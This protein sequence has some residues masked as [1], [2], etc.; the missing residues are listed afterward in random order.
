MS[1]PAN[2][3]RDTIFDLKEQLKEAKRD[4]EIAK[5]ERNRVHV[6]LRREYN[7]RLE[8]LAEERDHW[9]E[10]ATLAW[11]DEDD[12]CERLNIAFMEAGITDVDFYDKSIREL[13]AQRDDARRA[14]RDIGNA[15]LM[16][17]P[18]QEDDYFTEDGLYALVSHVMQYD[19]FN[20]GVLAELQSISIDPD[21]ATP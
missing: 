8:Q 13:T 12:L 3:L 21:E 17:W 1:D 4:A 16:V 6:D 15:T 9:K 11:K 20:R 10:R 19:K 14:L 7:G 5:G 2:N 18:A